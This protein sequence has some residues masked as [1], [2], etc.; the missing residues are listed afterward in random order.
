M[1]KGVLLA[2][3][4]AGAAVARRA[5]ATGIPVFD[6][7]S[8]ANFV[9]TLINLQQQYEQLRT[10]YSSTVGSRGF[11][12][13]LYDP[14][15]RDYLPPDWQTVY[16]EARAGGDVGFSGA[17]EDILN[18]EDSPA[19]VEETMRRIEQRTRRTAAADKAVGLR[20]YEGARQRLAQIEALMKQINGT[21]DQKA[22]QELQARIQVEQAAAQNEGTK[23]QL[24]GMLQQAEQKLIEE[25]KRDTNRKILSSR[26]TEMARF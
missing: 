3:V 2:V 24:I 16:D 19:S 9:T 20:G 23:L 13:I 21:G 15:L 6:A 4:L 25:K 5:E 8:A 7:A 18:S 11:G 17:L 26:N 14:A 1:R 12:S 10:T 22:A